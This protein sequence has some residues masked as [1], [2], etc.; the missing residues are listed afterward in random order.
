MPIIRLPKDAVNRIAAGEVV[1]RPA[2]VAK[3]LIENALDAGAWSIS[4]SA[5][6]GGISRLVVEDDGGG[7]PLGELPLAVERHATSKLVPGRDGSLDLLNIQTMGFR[8][9]ALPSIGSIARLSIATRAHD[10]SE[11]WKLSIDGVVAHGPNPIAWGKLGSGTIVEVSDLFYATPARLKFMKG[12]RSEA[13]AITEVVKRLAMARP[14]VA[15]SLQHDGRTVLRYRVGS[16][17]GESQR[18]QRLTDVLGESF[19]SNAFPLESIRDGVRLS[20]FAGLPT[21]SRGNA[22]HQFLFVNNR[23]VRDRL[24]VGAI[25]GA[26]QDVLARDR[27]PVLALFL[28]LD[29]QLV[30]ANVHP[31]KTEVR[32]RDPAGVR[33]L[34]VGAL[35]HGLAASG[36]RASTTVNLAALGAF[37]HSSL[38]SYSGHSSWRAPAYAVLQPSAVF[39]VS[40][41][42]GEL[43]SPEPSA[44]AEIPIATAQIAPTPDFPLGAAIAQLHGT[45]IVSQ[46]DDGIILVDQHAA[47]ERLVMERMKAAMVEGRTIRQPLLVP[48]IVD[49]EPA[50]AERLVAR[51]EELAQL[52]LVIDPFGEGAVAVMETPAILGKVN[53]RALLTD[54]VD[55]LAALDGPFALSEKLDHV[56]AT[57]AC[58]GSVRAGRMLGIDEM[59]ALLRQMEQTPR[60]GTCN[61]GRPTWIKLSLL[62]VERLFGRK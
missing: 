51:S 22:M 34:I 29:P 44:R 49:L 56:C 60:S 41:S 24:L 54:L 40:E 31:A 32:F 1:E 33:G 3:E 48:E 25:R 2:S 61:H 52:G 8:G 50:E 11:A 46:T 42:F 20:G 57:M 4:V 7:I 21:A 5:E 23:P 9:E 62:D 58:H 35:R 13:M 15:F 30:D 45:Y 6:A 10:S 27:H 59:N 36:V 19:G 47:H 14:D 16:G 17:D 26:Y 18:L 28:D 12:E 39:N 53:A 43:L 37:Q 38:P 55:D